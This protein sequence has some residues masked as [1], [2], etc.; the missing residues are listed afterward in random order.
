VKA[1][2]IVE[3]IR[4]P[5]EIDWSVLGWCVTAKRS[6]FHRGRYLWGLL[7]DQATALVAVSVLAIAVTLQA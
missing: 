2:H 7:T 5:T 6:V 4:F 1:D 3:S